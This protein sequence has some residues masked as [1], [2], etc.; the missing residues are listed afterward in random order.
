M[1]CV[2]TGIAATN[3][4]PVMPT[5]DVDLTKTK[6]TGWCANFVGVHISIGSQEI[7]ENTFTEMLDVPLA[8]RTAHAASVWQREL[9]EKV[10]Q[11]ELE[12]SKGV[13]PVL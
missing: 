11:Q 3:A 12:K 13:K 8:V 1:Q 10:R 6:F 5:D 7:V 2:G 4:Q 9:A